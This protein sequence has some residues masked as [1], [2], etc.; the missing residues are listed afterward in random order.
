MNTLPLFT[1][2][3]PDRIEISTETGLIL[4][5]G[6]EMTKNCFRGCTGSCIVCGKHL[7]PNEIAL[8]RL[9]LHI[10]DI[11]DRNFSLRAPTLPTIS[12]E[13]TM[14]DTSGDETMNVAT[15]DETSN[16]ETNVQCPICAEC[17]DS[18]VVRI[19]VLPCH[20]ATC[21][22][23]LGN[24]TFENKCYICRQQFF[25]DSIPYRFI[26]PE[27]VPFTDALATN[28]EAYHGP[29]FHSGEIINQP[30]QEVISIQES[31]GHVI[32]QRICLWTF[33]NRE[34]L[35]VSIANNI[36]SVL[37]RWENIPESFIEQSELRREVSINSSHVSRSASNATYSQAEDYE[38]HTPPNLYCDF[39][40]IIVGHQVSFAS[41]M[42]DHQIEDA[43]TNI[44]H[45]IGGRDGWL[46]GVAMCAEI[47][48]PG[49]SIS[50]NN[51]SPLVV[52][53]AFQRGPQSRYYDLIKIFV[54][55]EN[56][57]IE[58]YMVYTYSLLDGLSDDRVQGQLARHTGDSTPYTNTNLIVHEV[59]HYT[60]ETLRSIRDSAE[61][62]A[63]HGYTHVFDVAS[64]WP[65]ETVLSQLQDCTPSIL[66]YTTDE[67]NRPIGYNIDPQIHHSTQGVIIGVTSLVSHDQPRSTY[68][69]LGWATNGYASD[70]LGT[71][72]PILNTIRRM[73]PSNPDIL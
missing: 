31:Q 59:I 41:Y 46:A 38:V 64:A 43:R 44:G 30:P 57:V 58:K 63:S 15:A 10:P 32:N 36:V 18:D 56:G 34:A 55:I 33:R 71:I 21:I 73:L 52:R 7:E 13:G 11:T 2:F 48:M 66:L 14:D 16:Q 26:E 29:L 39:R 24:H 45:L 69:T 35:I 51:E 49:Q 61:Q 54:K 1:T 20:H 68:H 6:H 5:C 9:S 28:F 22:R 8:L 50:L 27:V 37:H 47:I 23:C 70:S 40:P 3:E 4:L 17:Y 60:G 65:N 42:T 12:E 19:V 67:D 72:H 62:Y 53:Y 25:I